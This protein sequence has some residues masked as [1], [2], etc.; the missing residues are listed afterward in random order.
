MPCALILEGPLLFL[1]PFEIHDFCVLLFSVFGLEMLCHF[2]RFYLS[3]SVGVGVPGFGPKS[4]GDKHW[5]CNQAEVG[6]WSECFPQRFH[7]FPP[8]L[9]YVPCGAVIPSLTYSGADP[10][11]GKSDCVLI[12]CCRGD[13]WWMEN[14]ST[15]LGLYVNL[16]STNGWELMCR[17]ENTVEHV[18]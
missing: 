15:C 16:I 2:G 10:A 3:A 18:Y 1:P 5:R 6:L 13:R 11:L 7:F 12:Q 8:L 4:L 17:N 9:F 14:E